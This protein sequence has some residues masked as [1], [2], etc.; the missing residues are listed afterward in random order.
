MIAVVPNIRNA[1]YDVVGYRANSAVNCIKAPCIMDT[2]INAMYLLHVCV[3][4]LI[5]RSVVYTVHTGVVIVLH[6]IA[7]SYDYMHSMSYAGKT[8]S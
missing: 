6:S 3:L 1:L 2:I 7:I 8:Y 4:Q 5:S